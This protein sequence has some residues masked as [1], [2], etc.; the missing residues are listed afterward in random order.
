MIG[1]FGLTEPNSG[2]DPGSMSTRAKKKGNSYILNGQKTW[3]IP[4]PLALLPSSSHLDYPT[5][6]PT[7]FY[8]ITNSPISD[9]MVIWAK[10]DEGVIRGFLLERGMKGLSTPEIE[11]KMSLRASITGKIAG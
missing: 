4:L 9:V 6:F 7:H 8:R 3:Y 2:S 10:D 11:G 5:D 1:C